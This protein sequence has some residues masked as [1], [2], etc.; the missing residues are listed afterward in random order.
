MND[1]L[2]YAIGALLVWL[3]VKLVRIGK[4]ESYLPNDPPTFP[5]LGNLN[6]FPMADVHLRYAS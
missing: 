6:I 3:V 2:L 1:L 5:L 4:R